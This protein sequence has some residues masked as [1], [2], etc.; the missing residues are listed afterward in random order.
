MY[1][2]DDWKS[3]FGDPTKFGLGVFS[4]CFDL[5]FMF[6]HYVLFRGSRHVYEKPGYRTID[7]PEAEKAPLLDSDETKVKKG[8]ESIQ[9]QDCSAVS[10]SKR[11]MK[12]LRLA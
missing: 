12:L 2:V 11:F 7:E 4:I 10:L 8:S 6:Q 1:Y 3:I 5:L 9:D